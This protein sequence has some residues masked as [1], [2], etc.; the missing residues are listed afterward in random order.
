M[1]APC[2]GYLSSYGEATTAKDGTGPWTV[3]LGAAI[4]ANS[5][6]FANPGSP[7]AYTIALGANNLTVGSG[8]IVNNFTETETFSNGGGSL[9]L[10]ASQTWNA[11]SGA[12]SVSA[13]VNLGANTLTV[14]GANA[15]TLSGVV[16]GNGGISR[17]GSGTLTLSGNNT[18]TGG[19]SISGG[20]VTLGNAGALNS[21]TPNAVSM[22]GGTL[23]INGNGVTISD[24]SGSSGTV[25]NNG[26]NATLTV[27]K[28]SG[29]SAFSGVLANGTGT[30][31]LTKSGAGTLVLSGANTY[32]GTTTISAGTLEAN[33]AGALGA[34]PAARS[35]LVPRRRLPRR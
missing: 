6:T 10:G 26:A 14:N 24:L 3:T 16:T 5:I 7:T 23:N 25:N 18:F 17:S 8:G 12:L 15:T 28:A 22:S 31:G 13:G 34:T 20:T 2:W 32:S 35:S 29:S 30:L 27:N 11:A 33:S 4:S 9:V 19:L 1:A 21:T